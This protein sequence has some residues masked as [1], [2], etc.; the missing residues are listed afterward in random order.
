LISQ[1]FPLVTNDDHE[2]ARRAEFVYD[3]LYRSIDS[4]RA[5][6]EPS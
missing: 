4:N 3:S 1:G 2:T 6:N 5:S